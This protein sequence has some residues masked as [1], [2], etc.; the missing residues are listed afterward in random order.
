MRKTAT[1]S[2]KQISSRIDN[3]FALELSC[4]ERMKRIMDLVI[5]RFGGNI[6]AYFESIR[7]KQGPADTDR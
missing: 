5:D 1:I 4:D 2:E 6:W 3:D 7:P